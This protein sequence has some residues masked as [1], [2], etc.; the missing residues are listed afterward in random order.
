M[1]FCIGTK[2]PAKLYKEIL[3]TAKKNNITKSM[4]FRKILEDY[5]A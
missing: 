5:F 4:V 1:D 3:K 2:V